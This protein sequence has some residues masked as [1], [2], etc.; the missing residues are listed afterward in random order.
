MPDVIT[1][2]ADEARHAVRVRRASAGSPVEVVDGEGRRARGILETDGA[3]DARVRI[4]ARYAEPP[5]PADLG[6]IVAL[7][8]GDTS[9]WIAEK[10]TELGLSRV[11]MV[12]A[13]RSIAR[14]A[15]DRRA[16]RVERWRR[17]AIEALK[18]CGRARLPEVRLFGSLAELLAA[19]A[20]DD[21][22]LLAALAGDA[23]PLREA[24]SAAERGGIRRLAVLVGPEGDFTPSEIATLRAAGAIPVSLG[25]AVLRVETAALAA[26]A[27]MSLCC[28]P[29]R[30]TGA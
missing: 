12:E 4:E 10:A 9:D 29:S 22:W 15:P 13:E 20:A 21:R 3:H 2:D 7:P 26:A 25:A 8:K 27:L 19:R 18:Q 17:T 23:M 16:A 24:L 14:V 11:W 6:L 30:R 5:P 28:C 1:L